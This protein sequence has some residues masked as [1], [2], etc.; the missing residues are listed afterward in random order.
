M[1][2]QNKKFLKS[3]KIEIFLLI[4]VIILI[5]VVYGGSKVL[6]LMENYHYTDLFKDY[7]NYNVLGNI[8]Y[9]AAGGNLTFNDCNDCEYYEAGP[10][11][12]PNKIGDY[13]LKQ[14]TEYPNDVSSSW[15]YE[16]I[17]KSNE[18]KLLISVNDRILLTP[19]KLYYDGSSIR[20]IKELK[21]ISTLYYEV[22]KYLFLHYR[23]NLKCNIID[24]NK[25]IREKNGILYLEMFTRKNIQ[26]VTIYDY[27][28]IKEMI[29]IKIS[30]SDATKIVANTYYFKYKEKEY[31]I[32]IIGTSLVSDKSYINYL[33]VN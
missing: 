21:N 12:V 3:E 5:L 9:N 8:E 31:W 26:N 33:K 13:E 18:N 27:D 11:Q 32:E 25:K 15:Y 30:D 28:N 1:K 6:L 4:I 10:F 19:Q 20:T 23:D 2:E 16:Y 29:E 17:D 24:T 14:Q 7:P 22:Y